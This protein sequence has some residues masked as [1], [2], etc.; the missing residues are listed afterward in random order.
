MTPRPFDKPPASATCATALAI[1]SG[2]GVRSTCATE[3]AVR[4]HP[5]SRVAVVETPALNIVKEGTAWP[6]GSA[7][8]EDHGSLH[9]EIDNR[10]GALR[11]H[12]RNRYGPLPIMQE[13][14][15]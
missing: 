15:T 13:R 12:E 3:G 5:V 9:D 11:D 7:D 1:A 8:P 4:P 10:G 14:K 2:S 6:L